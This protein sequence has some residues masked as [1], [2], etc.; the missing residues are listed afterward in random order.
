[1]RHWT[2]KF[3]TDTKP[4][5]KL[6]PSI[7]PHWT[8]FNVIQNADIAFTKMP[9]E[10]VSANG[11]HIIWVSMC[12]FPLCFSSR[13]WWFLGCDRCTVPQDGRRY[14]VCVGRTIRLRKSQQIAAVVPDILLWAVLSVIEWAIDKD[15]MAIDTLE[16]E[17]KV[18]F[19]LE[20]LMSLKSFLISL[21][22]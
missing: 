18:V 13:Q 11:G 20:L 22:I 15:T 19:S 21:N 9:F 5:P 16:P 14:F 6:T 17:V 8:H 1:M 4:L 7:G 12:W 10:I 2:D 3:L